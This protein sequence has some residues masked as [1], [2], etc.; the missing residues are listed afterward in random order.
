LKADVSN[1]RV[2]GREEPTNAEQA[3]Y[4][5]LRHSLTVTRHPPLFVD[6]IW[7]PSNTQGINRDGEIAD[8]SW[9]QSFQ[10]L[11]N[12]NDSQR[13]VVRAMVSTA[14]RDSLVIA[15]GILVLQRSLTHTNA[16]VTTQGLLE[17]GKQPR[18]PPQHRSG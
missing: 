8:L 18:L 9:T 17:Q 10:F 1:I 13:A 4:R 7:F 2:I 5:F 14:P 3:Q 16:D 6:I 11:T 15:H 12:L